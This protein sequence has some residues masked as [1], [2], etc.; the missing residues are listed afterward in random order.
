[1]TNDITTLNGALMELG[2]TMASNLIS[3]GVVASA[4]DGLTTLAGKILKVPTEYLVYGTDVTTVKSS[5]LTKTIT[6]DVLQMTNP[7][8]SGKLY[9]AIVPDCFTGTTLGSAI[10]FD[11]D[12]YCFEV[13][14]VD[15]NMGAVQIY[16]NSNNSI[17]RSFDGYFINESINFHLKITIISGVVKY[18]VDDDLFYTSSTFDFS[19]K[20]AFRFSVDPQT[21]IKVKNIKLYTI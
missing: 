11:D 12:D 9:L 18:Y 21:T 1:M 7:N 19:N 2:E 15:Y 8:T 10:Y 5:A 4:N 14:F 17:S 16:S 20:I 13:D 3:K 6:S